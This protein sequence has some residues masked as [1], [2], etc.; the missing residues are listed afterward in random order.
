MALFSIFFRG[1]EF[2]KLTRH[3]IDGE[4][5]VNQ[6]V[7][8]FFEFIKQFISSLLRNGYE[9]VVVFIFDVN[10]ELIVVDLSAFCEGFD[11][12]NFDLTLKLYKID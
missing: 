3:T 8:A 5:L 2:F 9:S 4:V 10:N 12:R 7:E 11:T 6:I 1:G